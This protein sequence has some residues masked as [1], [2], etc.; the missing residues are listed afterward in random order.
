MDELSED[1]MPMLGY[2]TDMFQEAQ[3]L[4]EPTGCTYFV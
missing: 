4:N 3:T 1:D 2:L